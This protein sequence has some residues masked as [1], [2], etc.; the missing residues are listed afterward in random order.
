M[1]L[2]QCKRMLDNEFKSIHLANYCEETIK[3]RYSLTFRNLSRDI[4]P[5]I[6]DWVTWFA[7]SSC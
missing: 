1:D 2:P 6:V 4:N 3:L 5:V 7:S